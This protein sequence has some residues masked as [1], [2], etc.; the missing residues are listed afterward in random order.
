MTPEEEFKR[1]YQL[2]ENRCYRCNGKLSRI[3]TKSPGPD[4]TDCRDYLGSVLVK[5]VDCRTCYKRRRMF[6]SGGN[7][8]AEEIND[9]VEKFGWP[10]PD[11]ELPPQ[12]PTP[13]TPP[14]LEEIK[15]RRA[16]SNA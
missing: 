6:V 12:E 14:T 2:F 4:F 13:P 16:C 7:L 11:S 9:L 5:C 8:R 10:I 3:D 1:N 15:A